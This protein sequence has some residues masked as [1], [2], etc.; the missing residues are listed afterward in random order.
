MIRWEE[1]VD[2]IV[3]SDASVG[4]HNENWGQVTLQGSVQE[5]KT[6]HVQH[7]DLVNK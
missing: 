7:M 2:A 6:L 5:G 4:G 3:P 1:N